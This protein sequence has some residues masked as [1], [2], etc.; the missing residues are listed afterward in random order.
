MNT[1]E[2][3]R[4]DY[5]ERFCKRVEKLTRYE[6]NFFEY[7][8]DDFKKEVNKFK[9]IDSKFIDLT[10]YINI[11]KNIFIVEFTLV[12]TY[13]FED[14]VIIQ[15][16]IMTLFSKNSNNTFHYQKLSDNIELYE[17]D[18]NIQNLQ[19]IRDIDVITKK[20]VI[21]YNYHLE[22]YINFDNIRIIKTIIKN[23]LVQ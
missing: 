20:N 12:L 5:T 3:I 16:Y 2:S 6:I 4:K 14:K 1:L 9:Y 18:V 7:V 8:N 23:T 10:S 13:Q 17:C 21:Y 19:K 22:K 11:R 15:S